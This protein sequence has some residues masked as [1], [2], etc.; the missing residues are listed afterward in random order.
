MSW[1]PRGAWLLLALC[2]P[3]S[4]GR[5]R[6]QLAEAVGCDLDRAAAMAGALLSAPH[7]AVAAAAG[8]WPRGEMSGGGAAVT[9]IAAGRAGAPVSRRGRLRTAELRFGH[10]FAVVAV[11]AGHSHRPWPVTA[12]RSPWQ[13]VPVF[14]AWVTQPEDARN[15]T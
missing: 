8:V 13:G 10:P 2:G 12:R 7:P 9:G 3:A 6:D 11:T 1:A 15:P 4:S 14:S 5:A